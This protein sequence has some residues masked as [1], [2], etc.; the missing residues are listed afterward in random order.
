MSYEFTASFGFLGPGMM[1]K[2]YILSQK[3]FVIFIFK[4]FQALATINNVSQ[5]T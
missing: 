3:L 4:R 5:H 1:P 2:N